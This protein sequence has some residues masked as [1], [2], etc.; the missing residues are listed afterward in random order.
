MDR[1]TNLNEIEQ[2]ARMEQDVPA[3]METTTSGVGAGSY[4][5]G[6]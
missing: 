4:R 1:S 2:F 5:G 3:I 6:G